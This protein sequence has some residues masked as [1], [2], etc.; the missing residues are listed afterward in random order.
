MNASPV[1]ARSAS[2]RGGVALIGLIVSIAFGKF[3]PN[4][5]YF[6]LPEDDVLQPLGH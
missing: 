1:A 6:F 5:L 2:G 3:P 4:Y